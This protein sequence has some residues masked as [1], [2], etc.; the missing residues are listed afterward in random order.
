MPGARS[1]ADD[2]QVAGRPPAFSRERRKRCSV[3]TKRAARAFA[4]S[5]NGQTG[6]AQVLFAT[7]QGTIAGFN[8]TVDPANAVTVVDNS[9]T[10]AVYT[11]LAAGTV[12]G[13]PVIYATDFHNRRIDVFDSGFSPVTLAGAFTDP[14]IPKRFA[15]FGIANINGQICELRSSELAGQRGSTTSRPG[16]PGCLH[17][18]PTS[19]HGRNNAREYS[20]TT[21]ERRA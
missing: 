8:S 17:A 6:T 12:N 4:I 7:E 11:G 10:G 21:G 19:Q 20:R 5:A 13:S 9:A 2:P 15:P 1:D 16:L 3:F 18:R 14:R